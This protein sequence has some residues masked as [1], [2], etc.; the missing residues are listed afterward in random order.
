[1]KFLKLIGGHPEVER[2]VGRERGEGTLRIWSAS[3]WSLLDKKAGREGL[4]DGSAFRKVAFTGAGDRNRGENTDNPLLG[5]CLEEE[6]EE[7]EEGE[8]RSLLPSL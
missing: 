2:E 7:E 5:D 6:E 1:L 4:L 3:G 8:Y